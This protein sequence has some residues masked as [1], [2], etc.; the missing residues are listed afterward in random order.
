[1]T[2]LLEIDQTYEFRT[3]NRTGIAVK[4]NRGKPTFRSSNSCEH[5]RFVFDRF[6][7]FQTFHDETKVIKSSDQ[8]IQQTSRLIMNE[9]NQ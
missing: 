1:M 5:F 8:Y 6:S 4:R 2:G 7:L 3:D 9:T